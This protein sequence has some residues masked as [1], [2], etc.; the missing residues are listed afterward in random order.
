MGS[1]KKEIMALSKDL[2]IGQ[3]ADVAMEATRLASKACDAI[4]MSR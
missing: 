4:K 2:A 3:P 1:W